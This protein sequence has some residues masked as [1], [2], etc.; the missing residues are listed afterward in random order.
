MLNNKTY[1]TSDKIEFNFFDDAI[2]HERSLD[3][4]S[5]KTMDEFVNKILP[6]LN[7]DI[8]HL[9]AKRLNNNI[10]ELG[11]IFENVEPMKISIDLNISEEKI[12]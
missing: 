9:I 4:F 10:I 3:R 8:N 12:K 6:E 2:D 11:K 5:F 7:T 1:T